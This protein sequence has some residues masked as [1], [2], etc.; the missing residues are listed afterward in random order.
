MSLPAPSVGKDLIAGLTTGVVLVAQAVAYSALAGLPPTAGLYAALVAPLVYATIGRS[1]VLAVGPT[2]ISSLLVGDALAHAA[3]DDMAL[4]LILASALAAM[5]GLL[6]LAFAAARL[7]HIVRFVTPTVLTGFLA[8]AALTIIWSLLPSL[9][10]WNGQWLGARFDIDIA[11]AGAGLGAAAL[12]LLPL[13]PVLER[14][15]SLRTV[16]VMAAMAIACALFRWDVP[17]VGVVPRGLP[18]PELPVAFTRGEFGEVLLVLAFPT[19]VVAVLGFVEAVGASAVRSAEVLEPRRELVAVGVANVAAGL[20]GGYP[21]SGGLSRTAVNA[22]AQATTRRAAV[23]SSLV[24]AV[25]LIVGND[26]LQTLPDPVLAAVVVAGILGLIDIPAFRAA[27]RAAQWVIAIT[28]LATLVF[29]IGVGIL[30]G[31]IVHT[32]VRSRSEP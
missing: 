11:I 6:Q 22:S 8:A 31:A 2:A 13:P 12:L 5:V 7:H 24:V 27:H 18:I 1:S 15:A 4:A 19:L 25:V 28:F 30:V 17:T 16:A 23:V 10:G 3:G 29:G 20:V 26:W 14:F 9:I 21:V 32:V